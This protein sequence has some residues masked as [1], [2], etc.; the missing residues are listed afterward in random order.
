MSIV[1]L[2]LFV[3]VKGQSD[4]N[5]LDFTITIESDSITKAKLLDSISAIADVYFSYNPVLLEA[6]KLIKTQYVNATIFSVILDIIDQN[7]IGFHALDNQIILYPLKIEKDEA[8]Q[9][10]VFKTIRGS[11]SD[12]K[13][14]E[15]IS[16]CN[17][18]I[19]GKGKGT[20]SNLD[21]NFSFK[22]PE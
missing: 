17:I 1:L 2:L 10:P 21:G 19:L 11:V 8:E 13:N 7:K 14:E 12:V 20:I 16:F 5:K 22:I 6:D 18:S 3:K 9:K 4:S 15:P